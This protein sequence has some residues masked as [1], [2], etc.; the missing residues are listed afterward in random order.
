MSTPAPGGLPVWAL[1]RFGDDEVSEHVEGVA[2][3]MHSHHP[4]ILLM[5][6]QEPGIVQTHD[7]RLRPLS[8]SQADLLGTE[9]EA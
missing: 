9:N 4:A 7:P 1:L 8:A 3:W 6:L 5:N 2:V